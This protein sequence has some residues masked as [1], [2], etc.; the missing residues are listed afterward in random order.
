MQQE[1]KTESKKFKKARETLKRYGLFERYANLK[2][3]EVIKKAKNIM[4]E[5]TR[6]VF[7]SFVDIKAPKAFYLNQVKELGKDSIES[8]RA[9]NQL[10]AVAPNASDVRK[11][12]SVISPSIIKKCNHG[13]NSAVS[14][15]EKANFIECI[16]KY[17]QK[18]S[19]VNNFVYIPISCEEDKLGIFKKDPTVSKQLKV[20][21]HFINRLEHQVKELRSH[22]AQFITEERVNEL[23]E[24]IYTPSFSEYDD[25]L[26]EEGEGDEEDDSPTTF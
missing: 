10:R 4:F 6:E 5:L 15:V 16:G 24:H 9:L 20:A 2:D 19:G 25:I 3:E 12:I 21:I 1:E 13:V 11:L 7:E 22:L 18:E 14:R 26:S 17:P 8:E 23:Y